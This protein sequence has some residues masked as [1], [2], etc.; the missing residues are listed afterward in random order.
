[1]KVCLLKQ[2]SLVEIYVS[3][4]HCSR[5]VTYTV[6]CRVGRHGQSYES[7]GTVLYSVHR[8]GSQVYCDFL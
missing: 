8:G 7:H 2:R 1:M 3:R 4:V 5:S 6:H